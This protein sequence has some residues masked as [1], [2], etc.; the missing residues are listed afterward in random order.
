MLNVIFLEIKNEIK[1]KLAVS[2]RVLYITLRFDY[3]V[4]TLRRE[5]KWSPEKGRVKICKRIKV[6]GPKHKTAVVRS[7]NRE[8]MVFSC[9]GWR[10]LIRSLSHMNGSNRIMR[11]H[12]CCLWKYVSS[13]WSI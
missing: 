7:I 2:N 8:V 11:G 1:I 10:L 6:K 9:E 13:G 4:I 5:R 12:R 3:R